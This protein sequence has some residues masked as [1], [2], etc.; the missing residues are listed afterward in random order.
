MSLLSIDEA[1]KKD[2]KGKYTRTTTTWHYN[3]ADINRRKKQRLTE[4]AEFNNF[5]DSTQC[6]MKQ[7]RIA[8]CDNTAIKCGRCANC[9]GHHFFE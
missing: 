5:V 2:S 7:A 4:L 9:K 8:L 6:Y 1:I 3:E